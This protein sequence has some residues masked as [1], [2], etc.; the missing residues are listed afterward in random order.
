MISFRFPAVE[1]TRKAAESFRKI[2]NTQSITQRLDKLAV[3]LSAACLIHC[4]I[5][6]LLVIV[7][8]IAGGFFAGEQ[9]H[10]VL[11]LFILPASLIALF[12]GC[13]RHGRLGVLTLGIMG[14]VVMTLAVLTHETIG[15]SWERVA[16]GFGGVL[17]AAG[18]ILNYRSCRHVQCE[19]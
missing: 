5:T 19:T 14:L 9:F 7:L 17:L 2:V 10:A 16:T 18:H 15:D 6:P 12:L 8:P 13:R 3:G 1:S 11:L 4:L